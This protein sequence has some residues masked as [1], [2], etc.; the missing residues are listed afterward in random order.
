[1][2]TWSDLQCNWFQLNAN[3]T[4][5][6]W[7]LV[8]LFLQFVARIPFCRIFCNVSKVSSI[9]TFRFPHVGIMQ[10]CSRTHERRRTI[11]IPPPRRAG[12]PT[13]PSS[14]SVAVLPHLSTAPRRP[15]FS[16]CRHCHL[17][18]SKGYLAFLSHISSHRMKRR[19]NAIH[20]TN[21]CDSQPAM[22]LRLAENMRRHNANETSAGK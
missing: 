19:L 5:F 7:I 17:S 4:Y 15:S 6:N 22:L 21:G 3:T 10:R 12:D 18:R 11:N 2:C 20:K 16:F 8:I 13:S 14:P 9:H 1:M